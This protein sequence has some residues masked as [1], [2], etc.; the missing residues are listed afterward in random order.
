MPATSNT[1]TRSFLTVQRWHTLVVDQN[2]LAPLAQYLATK[3]PKPKMQTSCAATALAAVRGVGPYLA[4]NIINTL[5]SHGFVEFDLGIV[6]PGALATLTW[7]RGGEGNLSSQGFW[8][9]V[10]G[11]AAVIARRNGVL[12]LAG[13]AAR[14]VPL[15]VFLGCRPESLAP[16]PDPPHR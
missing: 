12:P 6:G 1:K 16:A 11:P 2:V 15:A 4:K 3:P 14:L 9:T 13:Y 10:K 7:H 8:P 5:F